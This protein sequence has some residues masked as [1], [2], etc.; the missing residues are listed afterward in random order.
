VPATRLVPIV[1]REVRHRPTTS[2]LALVAV[3]AAVAL[4]NLVLLLARAEEKET[5]LIQ[6]DMGL[7]VLI[8]PAATDLDR[9]W[10]LGYSEH[11]M[12]AQYMER[13]ADQEV[14]NRLIPLLRRRIRWRDMD[15]MLTGIAAEVFRAGT[16]MKPVFGMR[17]PA[18]SLTL[19]GAVARHLSLAV[20]DEVELL[21]SSFRIDSVLA[22]VGGEEDVRV[23]ADLADAQRLLDLPGR[24]NEIQALECHCAEDVEDPLALLRS[25]LEPLL[26]GTRVVR[27]AQAAEARRRQRRLAENSLAV[28]VPAVLVLAGLLVGIL[29]ATN[30]RERRE[31]IGVLRALGY[32]SSWVAGLFLGRAV[33][34]GV[35]GALVGTVGGS[36][37]A[38]WLGPRIFLVSRNAIESDPWLLPAGLVLA[39]LFAA[40]ASLAPALMAT[41][42]DPAQV[43]RHE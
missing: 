37:L 4:V 16:K 32:G 19:G 15:V 41:R 1:L 11:S 12:P 20:G 7:N 38:A 34:L 29:A 18:G 6:R 35:V 42:Q 40:L 2:V 23:Y 22:E 39:P 17:I 36:A 43:L 28:T 5:R 10:S 24:I 31:E 8:L 21:G 9:Y 33:L 30:V 27:K 25:Q 13:V 26:P 14:A 3:A